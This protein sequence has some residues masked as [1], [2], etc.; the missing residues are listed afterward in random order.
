[1]DQG[2]FIANQ[3]PQ[4]K[5]QWNQNQNTN[6]FLRVNAFENVVWKASATLFRPLCV[7]GIATPPS[8]Y[9]TVIIW[10]YST[11]S[12]KRSPLATHKNNVWWN[13][14][15]DILH[16][17]DN[18]I[19]WKHFPR[20]W[21]Y[22][23]GI[24]RSPVNSPHKG[25]WRG[26]LMFSLIC[27]WIKYWVNNREAGDFRRHR[28]H[29]DVNEPHYISWRKTSSI[30][31]YMKDEIYSGHVIGNNFFVVNYELLYNF[32][33]NSTSLGMHCI[34]YKLEWNLIINC[35]VS[36]VQRLLLLKAADDE[37]IKTQVKYIQK[38]F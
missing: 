18:V 29:Y 27:A 12:L 8:P 34:L 4:N 1:M 5:L 35:G 37:I 33:H 16:N 6:V 19:K 31:H 14:S 11:Y 36:Y 23:R 22:V 2:W 17:H 32:M 20:C 25:Q 3:T 30:N 13:H 38:L 21:P 9:I 15:A 24:H 26:A 28:I 7:N 10:I